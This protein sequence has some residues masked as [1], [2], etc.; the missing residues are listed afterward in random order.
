M[1]V[2]FSYKQLMRG[3]LA[4]VVLAGS[5]LA[6]AQSLPSGFAAGSVIKLNSGSGPFNGSVVSGASTGASFESFCLEKLEYMNIGQNLYVQ[7]VTFATTNASG[8]YPTT[9]DPLSYQT[10]WLF[11]QYSNGAYNANAN[12]KTDMQNAFWHLEDEVALSA[13][14]STAQS[15]VAAANTAVTN[16]YAS[17]GNARVLNLYKDASYSMHSQ[18]QLVMLAPVPEPETYAMMLAGLGLMGAVARRRQTKKS[19]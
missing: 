12:V 17:Y 3:A 4:C 8:T 7:G 10:A 15:Y 6:F 13:L 2:I 11:T 19:A 9:S 18:D 16:G 14:S 1:N 5:Q